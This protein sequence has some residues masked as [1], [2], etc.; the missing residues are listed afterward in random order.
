MQIFSLIMNLN[1]L[2]LILTLFVIDTISC[3]LLPSLSKV[4]DEANNLTILLI[5]IRFQHNLRYCCGVLLTPRI[6]LT[7]AHCFHSDDHKKVNV[8]KVRVTVLKS[9]LKIQ[10]K[11]LLIHPQYNDWNLDNDAALLSFTHNISL[12][13]PPP[14]LP[15]IS[16]TSHKNTA[17]I[18]FGHTNNRFYT[19]IDNLDECHNYLDAHNASYTENMFCGDWHSLQHSCYG[20][21][22]CPI[23]CE[24]KGILG[25]V[26]F[27]T[28]CDSS[29]PVVFTNITKIR[30][31]IDEIL[32][33]M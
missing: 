31:W 8:S 26:S 6:A 33:R 22:G 13:L 25:I 32:P 19:N 3:R 16:D 7:A 30:D 28:S 21:S 9:S 20:D 5:R 24:G 10:P 18:L 4:D 17:C 1:R 23:I 2:P 12:Q 29:S 27:S 15:N 11:K 14:Y